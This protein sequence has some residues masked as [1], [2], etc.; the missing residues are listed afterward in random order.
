M[1][2]GFDRAFYPVEGRRNR[3]CGHRR[4]ALQHVIDQALLIDRVIGGLEK[5]NKLIS[6]EEKEIIAYHEAG[7]AICGWFLPY[8]DPLVKVSIVPRGMAALGYAQYLPKE[9]YLYSTEQ[10]LDSM[11]MAL[12]GRA[13]QPHRSG[14]TSNSDLGGCGGER[15]CDGRH[16]QRD[17]ARNLSVRLVGGASAGRG[18]SARLALFRGANCGSSCFCDCAAGIECFQSPRQLAARFAGL[19]IEKCLLLAMP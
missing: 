15:A 18:G 12:G 8:A 4:G 6:P 11:C 10:L 16:R 5:K 13:A 3:P 7:H 1:C 19:E 9:Q 2:I 14:C 17:C